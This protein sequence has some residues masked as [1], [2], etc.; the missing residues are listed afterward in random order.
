QPF[1]QQLS[2]SPPLSP[3]ATYGV[4]HRSARSPKSSTDRQDTM[5]P[6]QLD[7]AIGTDA[8]SPSFRDRRGSTQTPAQDQSPG[9]ETTTPSILPAA[10]RKRC[11]TK[12][13]LTSH[14]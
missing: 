12:V 11:R 6:T 3:Q 14:S 7:A 10:D 4:R 2:L 9:R 8:A 1:L 5:C 13:H